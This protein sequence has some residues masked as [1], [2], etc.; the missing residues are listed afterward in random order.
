MVP[1]VE[2]HH[3]GVRKSFEKSPS[4]DIIVERRE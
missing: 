4:I 2:L 1:Q 3:H